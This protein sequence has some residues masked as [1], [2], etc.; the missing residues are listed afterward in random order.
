MQSVREHEVSLGLLFF[1]VASAVVVLVAVVIP[2]SSA[3]PPLTS[4][5]PRG[6]IYKGSVQITG[7]GVGANTLSLGA[8]GSVIAGTGAI[9]ILPNNSAGAS[10]FWGAAGQAAQGLY[11]DA[12]LWDATALTVRNDSA[13]QHTIA[14]IAESG[15]F[16]AARFNGTV[17]IE[18]DL[19]KGNLQAVVNTSGGPAGFSS[20]EAPDARFADYGTGRTTGTSATIAIDPKFAETVELTAYMVFVSPMGTAAE[21]AVANQNEEGFTVVASEDTKF[22]YKIVAV[23]K[24]FLEKRF[25]R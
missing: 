10:Y 1:A 5:T 25:K 19:V 15:S 24:G 7:S 9:Y 6:T 22:A 8:G 16:P 4:G 11:L 18:G 2:V 20:L 17:R 23:R 3:T 13:T 14:A 12:H 21:I